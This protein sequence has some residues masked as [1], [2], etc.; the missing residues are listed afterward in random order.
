MQKNK[1]LKLLLNDTISQDDYSC[2]TEEI[3]KEIDKY[4]FETINYSYN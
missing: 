4:T 2:F 1:T 3:N